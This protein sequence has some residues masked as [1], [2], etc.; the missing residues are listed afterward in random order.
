MTNSSPQD[1]QNPSPER[2]TT[3][4]GGVTFDEMIGII[5]AFSTIGAIL[6]WS[7]GDKRGSF[8]NSF[9]LGGRSNLLSSD[10][11]I[12]TGIGIVETNSGI[13]FDELESDNRKL[14]ARLRQQESPVA[15]VP[16]SQE[17]NLPPEAQQQSYQFDSGS[18][19]VP[20]AGVATLPAL[21]N[22]FN[23]N[24]DGDIDNANT[25]ITKTEPE[26]TIPNEV[27]IE[28]P[29]KTEPPITTP[30]QSET[31]T[32]TEPQVTAPEQ[33]EIPNDVTPSYWAYPFVKRITDQKLIAE[34]EEEQN[35][36]PDKLITRSAMATLISQAFP[37]QPEVQGIK[38]FDDVT[39]QN[40][41]AADIDKAVRMGFMHGYSH[42]EFRP[43]ENIPRYQVLVALAEG[44]KLN[45]E[46]PQD[47][48]RVLQK[49]TDVA[50]MPDWA[51][52]QVAAA[53]AAG[54]IV[55]RPDFDHN[56]LMPNESATRAEVV[57]MIHQALVKTGK[58]KPLQS[59][60]I[61]N[62]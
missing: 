5:V 55:N 38:Q 61:F 49:F 29:A 7:L 19:L 2:R 4:A 59:E 33:S 21:R 17:L 22:N 25:R 37:M 15:F 42:N 45:L 9:G 34:L 57:A 14:A 27:E 50:D 20:L 58:L 11:T 18:K 47:A 23:G 31:P 8:F 54:L 12:E 40:A 51:K 6:F 53:A 26:A 48:D 43:L 1:P 3:P 62:P 24:K 32:K 13:N 16:P 39:N 36:E 46:P 30:E 10:K 56:S 35:F 41:I 52:E 44:L 60:Y 28:T